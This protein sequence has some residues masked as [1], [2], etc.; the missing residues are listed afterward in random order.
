MYGI[1][2][3]INGILARISLVGMAKPP[4]GPPPEELHQLR[5]AL[6]T[7]LRSHIAADPRTKGLAVTP[8][9]EEISRLSKVGKNTVLRALN[10]PRIDDEKAID[11]QLETLVR[12]AVFFGVSAQDLLRDHTRANRSVARRQIGTT[13]KTNSRAR[14]E[15][16]DSDVQASLRRSRSV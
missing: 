13:T 6:A 5:V 11:I 15:G 7:N 4:T 3:P 12:L 9:A 1:T 8:A 10:P 16:K 2:Q 14:T